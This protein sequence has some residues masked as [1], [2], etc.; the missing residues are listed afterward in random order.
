MISHFDA[1]LFG[2]FL[3]EKV[4]V[5]NGVKH[6][7][8][9]VMYCTKDQEGNIKAVHTKSGKSFNADLF[10]DCTGFKS[11]LIEDFMGVEFTSFDDYLFNDTALACQIPYIDKTKQKLRT[12]KIL[13][14]IEDLNKQQKEILD[15]IEKLERSIQTKKK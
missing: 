15:Y 8:E 12:D 1:A 13:L 10:V 7:H 2:K 4:A 6:F 9:K 14:L 5:P 11:L 3:K